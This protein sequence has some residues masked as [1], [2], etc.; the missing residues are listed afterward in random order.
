MD[1][2]AF[3]KSLSDETPPVSLRPILKSLWYAGKDNW[4]ASHDI[5]QDIHS[6]EGSWVHAYLHRVDLLLNKN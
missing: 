5:A 6:W 1:F 3:K 4:D 2:Q